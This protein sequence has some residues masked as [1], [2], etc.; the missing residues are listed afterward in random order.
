VDLGLATAD[1]ILRTLGERLRQQ[2]LTQQL[3]Q[4][5]LAQMAGVALGTVRKLE[6]SGVSSLETVVRVVQALGLVDELQGLFLLKR[7]SFEEITQAAQPQRQR[8]PR[9]QTR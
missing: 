6:Q 2:R 4:H 5:E 8:A 3:S 1:E 7:N 9:K